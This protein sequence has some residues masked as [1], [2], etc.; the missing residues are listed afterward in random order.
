MK[1]KRRMP[2]QPTGKGNRSPIPKII[3]D[4]NDTRS[5]R[6]RMAEATASF[7]QMLQTAGLKP[8]R[9]KRKRDT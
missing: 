7:Q 8:L 1:K 3:H 4:P 6:D 9:H 5:P 2:R